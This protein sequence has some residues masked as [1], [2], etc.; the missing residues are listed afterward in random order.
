MITIVD[1]NMGNLGSI[2]NM[3]RKLGVESQITKDA[4]AIAA[5]TKLILPGVGS[6]DAGMESLRRS[7]LVPVLEERVL[8]ARIPTLGICL[9]MQLMT[10]ASEEGR[11]PGLCVSC[12][13]TAR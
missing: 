11:L 5:A 8:A 3:L 13:Q 7:G 10:R 9:G 1:Y 2:R 12:R 4:G 6:F